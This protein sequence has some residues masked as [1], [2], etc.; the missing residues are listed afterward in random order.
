M[1]ISFSKKANIEYNFR[2]CC[3]RMTKIYYYIC[4][5]QTTVFVLSKILRQQLHWTYDERK[6]C[7]VTHSQIIPITCY[8]LHWYSILV[9]YIFMW[10]S[11]NSSVSPRVNI[12]PI[13]V[14]GKSVICSYKYDCF[15]W[16]EVRKFRGCEKNKSVNWGL[17]FV[18]FYSSLI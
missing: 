7:A 15:T 16:I 10:N 3:M 6:G 1:R 11:L 12:V 5:P 18:C 14:L 8:Y 9:Y 17:D 2:Y 4:W 13:D